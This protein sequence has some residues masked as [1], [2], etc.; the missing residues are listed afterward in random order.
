MKKHSIHIDRSELFALR[1]FYDEDI[2]LFYYEL[3]RRL[4][5]LNC[6]MI[7]TGDPDWHD[8]EVKQE[9]DGSRSAWLDLQPTPY[10]KQCDQ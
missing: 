8:P 2:G 3:G 10:V 1:D 4:Y 6:R 7:G 9:S 5:G